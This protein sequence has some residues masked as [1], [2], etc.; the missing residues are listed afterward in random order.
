[1]RKAPLSERRDLK[2]PPPLALLVSC[3]LALRYQVDR[4]DGKRVL[5]LYSAEASE[6]GDRG[7]DSGGAA[8]VSRR[9]ARFA[10]HHATTRANSCLAYAFSRCAA[11]VHARWRAAPVV[12]G[13][14][15]ADSWADREA[16]VR[17]EEVIVV[18]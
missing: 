15:A 8:S 4:A 10:F 7:M 1:L 17:R 6:E 14:V 16:A 13:V 3:C 11:S 9:P 12:L 2:S 5:T 18:A